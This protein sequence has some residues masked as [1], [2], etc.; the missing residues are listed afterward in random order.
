[1]TKALLEL[2]RSIYTYYPTVSP[3][4]FQGGLRCPS[5]LGPDRELP[6]ESTSESRPLCESC[7]VPAWPAL[8]DGWWCNRCRRR[9]GQSGEAE[10]AGTADRIGAEEGREV[11]ASLAAR[12]MW[13]RLGEDGKPRVGPAHLVTE[14]DRQQLLAHRQAVLAAL[15]AES[16]PK[17]PEAMPVWPEGEELIG[18]VVLELAEAYEHL[19]FPRPPARVSGEEELWGAIEAAYARQDRQYLVAA[20]ARYRQALCER[21]QAAAEAGRVVGNR[22]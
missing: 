17:L 8:P 16:Q 18:Q 21:W 15:E 9:W 10:A 12:G 11:L 7:G 5:E 1:M 22:R 14:Q 20:L 19:P 2:G 4:S 13:V 3:D 6:E